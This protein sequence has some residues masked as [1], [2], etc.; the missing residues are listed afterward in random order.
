MKRFL[1][2]MLLVLSFSLQ[3]SAQTSTQKIEIFTRLWGFLKYHHINVAAGKSDWDSVFMANIEDIRKT[4]SKEQFNRQLLSIIEALGPVEKRVAVKP[5]DELFTGNFSD[6][7]TKSSFL[8]AT[9]KT[10]LREIYDYRNQ[11]PNR[12]IKL[13]NMTAD[14]SGENPYENIGFPDIQHR[15]LFLARFYNAI[16]YFAPYK[17][18]IGKEWD[19]MLSRFVPE[20]IA[21]NDTTSY[22]KTLLK[23]AVALNDG[24]S[25]VSSSRNHS[26]IKD[27][28]FGKYTA[29]FHTA[30]VDGNVVITKLANDTLCRKANIRVGDIVTAV[31][32]ESVSE[33]IKR[34]KPYVSASNENSRDHYLN[35]VFF[36]T[37]DQ[38]Q[39]LTLKRAGQSHSTNTTC[40][41]ITEKKWQ[42]IANYMGNETGYKTIGSSIAYV[43]AAQ[44]WKGNL[45]QIKT[46][47]KSKQAVIFDVRNYPN[48]D[49]FY[50][51]FDMFLPEGRPINYSLVFSP[52]HPG[53]FK[54]E[55]SPKL[56]DINKNI[57]QGK[58]LILADERSQSQGEYSVM[59]LQT[60]PGAVTIGRQTAGADGIVTL[61]PMGGNL[62]ISYSGYG[63]YYPDRSGTQQSGVKIDIPVK[64]T[65]EAVLQNKDLTL[66]R[67]LEYLSGKGI[68]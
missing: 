20:M 43:Y 1:M 34:L 25:Q 56:G 50:S 12:Y 18:L 39:Q 26:I 57:Y 68:N 49:D 45:E 63:I 4:D 21:A 13:Q 62:T 30:I 27:N 3:T 47:I 33:R 60:I 42:D 67:A 65:L 55:L 28:V 59:T 41:L 16:N 29:P 51:I 2:L 36:D 32:K 10:R 61:I 23:L 15:L 19:S 31:D 5:A 46:L 64:Q 6:G 66:D 38:N 22:Y 17:Y 53:Y 9:L 44:I 40:I 7:W 54:W 52:E 8:N 11:G 48:N 58:V 24:H 14:Y 37:P 35:W